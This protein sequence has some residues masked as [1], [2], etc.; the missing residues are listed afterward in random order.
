[1][2]NALPKRSA[3]PCFETSGSVLTTRLRCTN[4]GI[5]LTEVRVLGIGVYLT[6]GMQ[7]QKTGSI[8]G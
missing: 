3:F 4:D 5:I 8:Y 6:F 1:M 2:G 7:L